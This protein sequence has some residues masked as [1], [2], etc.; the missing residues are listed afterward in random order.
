MRVNG[1]FC[2]VSSSGTIS[3]A[4]ESSSTAASPRMF[5]NTKK[6]VMHGFGVFCVVDVRRCAMGKNLLCCHL[7][8][9]VWQFP[10]QGAK[11]KIIMM[12]LEEKDEAE[13]QKGHS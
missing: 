13:T 4:T 12:V 3:A 9:D 5:V 8:S 2:A 7:F 11:S 6:D 1:V 10:S